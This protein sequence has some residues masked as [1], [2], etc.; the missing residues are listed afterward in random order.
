MC[1]AL[2][3][4]SQCV[5]CTYK[6]KIAI[7]DCWNGF[8][9]FYVHSQINRSP[10]LHMKRIGCI[11]FVDTKQLFQACNNNREEGDVGRVKKKKKTTQ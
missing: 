1:A 4:L 8:N 2:V 6:M 3:S 10:I 9:T 7:W 5:Q 11:R